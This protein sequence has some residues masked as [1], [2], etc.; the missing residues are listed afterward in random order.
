MAKTGKADQTLLGEKSTFSIT[1]YLNHTLSVAPETPKQGQ[2]QAANDEQEV[3][4]N[5]KRQ[6]IARPSPTAENETTCGNSDESKTVLVEAKQGRKARGRNVLADAK[7]GAINTKAPQKKLR[8]IGTL[9]KVTEEETDEN[10]E[11]TSLAGVVAGT[12]PSL[13][14]QATTAN[15][16]EAKKKKRK[17]LGAVKTIFDEDDGEATKRP[18]KVIL[19]PARTLAGRQPSEAKSGLQGGQ[20]GSSGAFGAFSPLKKDRRGAQASFLV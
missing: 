2:Q 4:T 10:A 5:G 16:A 12:K 1:P 17:L 3:E 6:A 18:V 7:K 8:M 13:H 9:E 19:G 15:G 14:I 20:R 11:P